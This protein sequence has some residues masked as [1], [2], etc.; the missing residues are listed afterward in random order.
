MTVA[1]PLSLQQERF[2]TLARA[3]N[4]PWNLSGDLHIQ[5]PLRANDVRAAFTAAHLRHEALRTG[6]RSTPA[7]DVQVVEPAAPALSIERV[8]APDNATWRAV[9]QHAGAEEEN[10]RFDLARPPLYRARLLVRSDREAAFLFTAHHLISDGWSLLVFFQELI[11]TYLAIGAGRP[12]PQYQVDQPAR[13]AERELA[14]HASPEYQR[15][16]DYWLE[17]LSDAPGQILPGRRVEEFFG[18]REVSFVPAPLLQRISDRAEGAGTDLSSV[19]LAA[20]KQL[21]ARQSGSE[22]VVVAVPA[23][24][25]EDGHARRAVG[26]YA[27]A[28]LVRTRIAKASRLQD[29]LAAVRASIAGAQA[30]ALPTAAIIRELAPDDYARRT[31]FAD[32]T[33]NFIQVREPFR[34]VGDLSVELLAGL[35][36]PVSYSLSDLNL[37]AVRTELGLLLLAGYNSLRLR[38]QEVSTFLTEYTQELMSFATTEEMAECSTGASDR[39]RLGGPNAE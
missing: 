1:S 11:V 13:F 36:P 5:G 23:A 2:F 38:G 20:L 14:F 19:L 32:V 24:N 30:H 6:F 3:G 10:A 29:N 31:E 37:V 35:R 25:R 8:D 12:L 9:L 7:G 22:D 16:L 18:G 39:I 27:N 17:T 15:R 26:L 33:F 4:P 28:L 21:L 34:A